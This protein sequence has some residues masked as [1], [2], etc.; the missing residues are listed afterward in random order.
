MANEIKLFAGPSTNTLTPAAWAALTSLLSN[1]FSS[2]LAS[3]QQANT[4]FRQL[5]T[6]A[7][8]VGQFI[9]DQGFDALDNG[10]INDFATAFSNALRRAALPAGLI[11]MTGAGAAPAGTMKLNGTVIPINSTSQNLV[12]AVYCGDANNATAS[13]FYKCT[14]SANPTTSRSTAGT[15]FVLEDTRGRFPRAWVDGGS[16]DVGRSLWA[17]QDDAIRNIV[18]YFA[19]VQTATVTNGVF[20]PFAGQNGSDSGGE[21]RNYI[22]FDASRVVP[23]AA[24]N[25]PYNFPALFVITL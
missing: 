24:D 9:S 1:G 4:L 5:S 3:S 13:F 22:R 6:V 10:N 15:F 16:I 20:E 18:G 8:G 23:T 14:D 7:A 2:G 11:L 19:A 17:M 25:R 12:D 21:F